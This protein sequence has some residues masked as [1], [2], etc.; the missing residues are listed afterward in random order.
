MNMRIV[1]I[2]VLSLLFVF[3]L[4]CVGFPRHMG[5][6]YS[7]V[8]AFEL[9]TGRHFYDFYAPEYYLDQTSK[10]Q[11]LSAINYVKIWYQGSVDNDYSMQFQVNNSLEVS[12][13]VSEFTKDEF[14]KIEA[15]YEL[16]DKDFNIYYCF[17]SS[18][19]YVA[20]HNNN[21]KSIIRIRINNS[22]I[23]TELDKMKTIVY[24]IMKD[25]IKLN[26]ENH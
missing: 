13:S 20:A 15:E 4:L 6:S 17:D 2:I 9:S 23:D 22:Q 21:E 3:W 18:G 16:I 24:E 1:L 25:S 26:E 19:V 12:Y 11:T 7:S 14:E 5:N 8:K 10:K